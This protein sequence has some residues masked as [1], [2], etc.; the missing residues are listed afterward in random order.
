[1]WC[2]FD[3]PAALHQQLKD[4]MRPMANSS[5]DEDD[6]YAMKFNLLYTVYSIPNIILPFFGGTI[7]D[8]LGAPYSACIFTALTLC[9]QFIFA[10]G[11][12]YNYGPLCSLAE[13]FMDSVVKI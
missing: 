13:S 10:M 1:M 8:Q 9:G 12:Q 4:Y 6:N 2:R 11:S 3:I 5:Y 7:V